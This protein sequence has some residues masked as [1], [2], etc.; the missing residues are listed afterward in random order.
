MDGEIEYTGDRENTD[1]D[2]MRKGY[3]TLTPFDFDLTNYAV[4]DSLRA[5][6]MS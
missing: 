2:M 6:D 5:W 4:L 1:L 3:V